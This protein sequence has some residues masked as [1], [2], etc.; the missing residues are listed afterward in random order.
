MGDP[1]SK[2]KVEEQLKKTPNI[3]LG[4]PY[5]HA[6]IHMCAYMRAHINTQHTHTRKDKKNPDLYKHSFINFILSE[7][8]HSALFLITHLLKH[9]NLSRR[10]GILWL[11]ERNYA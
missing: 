1:A 11:I 10:M 4:S 5:A 6:L 9:K 3:I 2:N 8:F 7:M